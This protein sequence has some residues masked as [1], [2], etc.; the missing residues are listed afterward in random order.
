MSQNPYK[1]VPFWVRRKRE[2]QNKARLRSASPVSTELINECAERLNA[3]A[4][5]PPKP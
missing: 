2:A 5:I 1:A 3:M 4:A